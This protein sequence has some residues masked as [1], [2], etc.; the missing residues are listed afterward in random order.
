VLSLLECEAVGVCSERVPSS[1]AVRP[2][3][4]ANS[5]AC[6][7]DIEVRPV[8]A[9]SLRKRQEASVVTAEA[10]SVGGA[11]GVSVTVDREASSIDSSAV[12]SERGPPRNAPGLVYVDAVPVYVELGPSVTEAGT[13]RARESTKVVVSGSV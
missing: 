12:N 13:E 10:A 6:M 11:E 4:L 9:S 3:E 8:N 7:S 1:V 5:L 2:D